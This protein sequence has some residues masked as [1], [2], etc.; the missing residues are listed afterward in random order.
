[1]EKV[2]CAIAIGAFLPAPGAN[3]NAIK[4]EATSMAL[5]DLPHK[6]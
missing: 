5:I 3:Q 1:M 4:S 6:F 2:S